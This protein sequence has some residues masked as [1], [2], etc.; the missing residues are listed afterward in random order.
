[1][2]ESEL[3]SEH[4]VET[5]DQTNLRTATH[6]TIKTIGRVKLDICFRQTRKYPEVDNLYKLTH[7]FLIADT[8]ANLF[9]ADILCEEI[10]LVTKS[11]IELPLRG[12]R[13]KNEPFVS[14]NQPVYLKE[15]I[16]LK[17][18]HNLF[19]DKKQIDTDI[20]QVG[21]INTTMTLPTFIPLNKYCSAK[22]EI[23]ITQL[24]RNKD[25]LLISVTK[26]HI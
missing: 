22:G 5:Y 17:P 2:C 25:E 24:Q 9:G 4:I 1:M 15:N 13:M 10:Q 12:Y 14:M 18:N 6:D 8:H 21:F 3:Y 7:R 16:M 19:L 23:T 26:P 11:G 20:Q